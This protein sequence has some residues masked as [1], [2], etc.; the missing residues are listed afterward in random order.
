MALYRWSGRTSSG[1]E[2]SG[3]IDAPSKDEAMLKL[4]NQ[5]VSI[6]AITP[7]AAGDLLIGTSVV[8]GWKGRLVRILLGLLLLGGATL[9]SMI[10]KGARIQCSRS[11]ASY[12]CTVE[13]NMAGFHALYAE[14]I[15]GVRSAA[16]EERTAPTSNRGGRGTK[17]TRVVV[18][19]EKN[20]LAT[21]WMAHPLPSSERVAQQINNRFAQQSAS[22]GTWQV[23]SPPVGVAAVFG[24]VGLWLLGSGL[25]RRG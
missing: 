25:L 3:T 4:R 11:G 13:T 18:A 21:D 8:P 7:Q 12:D 16:A 9:M 24:L 14:E 15:R 19:A 6:T 22:F 1:Q 23:E 2:L 5:N 10:A 17:T 20:T